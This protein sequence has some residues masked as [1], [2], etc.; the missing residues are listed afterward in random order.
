MPNYYRPRRLEVVAPP[1]PEIPPR[2][3]LV[4]RDSV[5]E[6]EQ[7]VLSF[8]RVS[9]GARYDRDGIF[10]ALARFYEAAKITS[11]IAYEALG[12]FD[13]LLRL[14]VPRG[15]LPE[16][17]AA[18]LRAH[19]VAHDVWEVE[20]IY[21]TLNEHWRLGQDPKP[22]DLPTKT[23]MDNK[24]VQA[25]NDFND[26]QV[27]NAD[28]PYPPGAQE[29][30]DANLLGPV[31]LEE[32]GIRFYM[33]MSRPFR[34][35]SQ[36]ARQ[37]L[38]SRLRE[39]CRDA[40]DDFHRHN[41]SVALPTHVSVYS[42]V[43]G[44][45]GEFLLLGRAPHGYFHDFIRDLS[46]RVRGLH[47]PETQGMRP[48][49]N[50][51][52]DRMFSE[53][54]EHRRTVAVKQVVDD[55]ADRN[56]DQELEYKATFSVDFSTYINTGERRSKDEMKD[57]VLRTVCGML[58]SDTG[59]VLVVGV[60]EVDR[61]YQKALRH[62]VARGDQMLERLSSEF[63]YKPERRDAAYVRP[64]ANLTVGV[65]LEYMD[66]QPY[67]SLDIVA[68]AVQTMLRDRIDPNP[69][70]FFRMETAAQDGRTVLIIQVSPADSWCYARLHRNSEE[71]FFVR[72][73]A[74]TRQYSRRETEL[75]Q[76]AH[77]REPAG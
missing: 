8:W 70:L 46:F 34:A 39:V 10:E 21:C 25:I 33:T 19:L 48:H 63:G 68:G 61:E 50:V 75:Y 77:R 7:E 53:C 35:L 71:A 4:W 22:V 11:H 26:R 38:F 67:A 47:L 69:F 45:M 51:L 16:E 14:W 64:L 57:A 27:Q 62:S 2:N 28:E 40:E 30:I 23:L 43:G 55:I 3:L 66:G 65:E 31:N 29:L 5:H 60:V 42:G 32:R 9:F 41:P 6:S 54:T 74:S 15:P 17:L 44:T 76:R 18:I 36:A 49:T 37:D 13:L 1:E 12:D 73:A 20:Y 24:V 52:A 58:N 59:G 56:E 72:E